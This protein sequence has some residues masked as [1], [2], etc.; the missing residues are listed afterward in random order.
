MSSAVSDPVLPGQWVLRRRLGQA[1]RVRP[2]REKLAC[3]RLEFEREIGLRTVRGSEQKR[4]CTL[5]ACNDQ[6]R[7]DDES[8]DEKWAVA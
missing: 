2:R 4:G 8:V 5:I 7:S 1:A 3:G 6:R